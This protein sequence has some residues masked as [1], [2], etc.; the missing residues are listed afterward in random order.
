MIRVHNV[1]K[2]FK[3]YA[4]PKDRLKEQIFE[5]TYHHEYSALSNIS[6]EVQ[7]GET[8]G[9]IGENGAGKS[10]LLK[11][12]SGV[13]LPD[14]GS[15]EVTGKVT[16][17]LELG[18]GFNPELTGLQNIFMNGTFLGMTHDEIE[19]KKETIIEFAE[20]GDFIN[21]PIKTYSS[22]MLMRLGFAIAIHADP[23][24]FL[25]DEALSV[26]DAYFQHK[27]MRKINEFKE[28]G[29][30]IIFVSHDTN[31]VKVL[32]DS[33]MMLDGGRMIDYGEP[34]NV[35]DFYQGIILKRTHQGGEAVKV[36]KIQKDKKIPNEERNV[37]Q[38]NFGIVT[39]T[40]EVELLSCTLLNEK[41][42]ETSYIL[43]ETMLTIVCRYLVH[44]DLHDPHYGFIIRNSLGVSISETNTYCM[45]MKM[46]SVRNDESVEVSFFMNVPLVPG[47]YSISLGVA[48]K[49]Y[50]RGNFEQYLLLAQ[51]VEVIRVISNDA[52]IRFGGVFNINPK[53]SIRGE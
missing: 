12:L 4:S 1:S 2:T 17:L 15:V 9:I 23:E 21:E 50:E 43:S 38:D 3:I 8:L 6:F 52:S 30:S 22:G 11:I 31:A 20:L 26:G 40:G 46:P 41:G 25:V 34:K 7:P 49:G 13:L 36:Q 47:D 37:D 18:T 35:V 5:H 53:V 27:C 24:C 10:T 32:C 28:Q 16:G 14:T 44:K 42:K 48:E 45:G 29:G 33:A 51:D 19:S 39:G